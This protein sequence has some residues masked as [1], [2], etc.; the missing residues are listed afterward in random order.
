[1]IKLDYSNYLKNTKFN[2]DENFTIKINKPIFDDSKENL[3]Q[4]FLR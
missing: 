2:I 3:S 1:M 4:K